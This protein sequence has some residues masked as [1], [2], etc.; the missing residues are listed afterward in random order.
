MSIVIEQV[1]SIFSMDY[2]NQWEN[3]RSP[4]MWGATIERWSEELTKFSDEI[5]LSAAKR[6]RKNNK[7][8]PPNLGQFEEICKTISKEFSPTTVDKMRKD[9]EKIR[10]IDHLVETTSGASAIAR[11]EHAKIKAILAGKLREIAPVLT[12]PVWEEEKVDQHSK[13]FDKHLAAQRDA[14]LLNVSESDALGL[15]INDRYDRHRLLAQIQ[16]RHNEQAYADDRTA[17]RVVTP[18]TQS[19]PFKRD[20][21]FKTE[22][23]VKNWMDGRN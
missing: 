8:F 5:V 11:R 13:I 22:N 16:T 23:V 6:A 15:E 2:G 12:I 18:E 21:K 9:E 17:G 1:F 19:S 14:F 20:D 4:E 10:S 7:D 3:S